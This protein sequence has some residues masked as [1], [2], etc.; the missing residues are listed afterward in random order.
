M[1]QYF[2]GPVIGLCAWLV[3]VCSL[4]G[5]IFRKDVEGVKRFRPGN[6]W[7]YIKLPFEFGSYETA[8]AMFPGLS[9]IDRLTL[10]NLNWVAM[11]GAGA[12]GSFIWWAIQKIEF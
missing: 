1:W 10:L 6:L 8:W 9:L 11:V 2:V 12:V 3:G 7:P 5:V 4:D